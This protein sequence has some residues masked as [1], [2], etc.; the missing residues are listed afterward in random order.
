MAKHLDLLKINTLAK[1]NFTWLSSQD[2]E[3]ILNVKHCL[4]RMQKWLL[5]W[6]QRGSG[7]TRQNEVPKKEWRFLGEEKRE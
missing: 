1:T 5:T 3:S 4:G 6:H 7:T 2:Q